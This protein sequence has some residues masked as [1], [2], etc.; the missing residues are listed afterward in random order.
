MERGR[1]GD[2]CW[3]VRGDVSMLAA[4]LYGSML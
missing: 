2:V 1:Q 4:L 3:E